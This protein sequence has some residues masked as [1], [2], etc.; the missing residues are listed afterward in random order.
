ML[1]LQKLSTLQLLFV[2]MVIHDI[3][4][5]LSTTEVTLLH[6]YFITII[7]HDTVTILSFQAVILGP[8]WLLTMVEPIQQRKMRD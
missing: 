5:I 3:Y 1:M 8:C 7:L 4:G 6:F 2:I